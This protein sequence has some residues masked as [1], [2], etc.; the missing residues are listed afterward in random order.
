MKKI[1]SLA[2]IAVCCC[3]VP[4]QNATEGGLAISGYTRAT[5]FLGIIN[6]DNPT[7]KSLYNETSLKLKAKVVGLRVSGC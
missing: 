3:Q 5:G 2:I 6:H 4:A 1:I 7:L